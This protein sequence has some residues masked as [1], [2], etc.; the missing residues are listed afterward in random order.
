MYK[1]VFPMITSHA[2]L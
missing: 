2:S 1:Y